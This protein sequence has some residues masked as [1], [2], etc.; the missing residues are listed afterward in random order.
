[1]Q[2][3]SLIRRER[4]ARRARSAMVEVQPAQ[5]FAGHATRPDA[6]AGDAGQEQGLQA[7]R[8]AA[9]ADALQGRGHVPGMHAL[10]GER[11]RWW[12]G[13]TAWPTLRCSATPRAR[14]S[15]FGGFGNMNA[16]PAR[17]VLQS[18]S[19]VT[20]KE[21]D[22]SKTDDAT[23]GDSDL[24]S[25]A[26]V[27]RSGRRSDGRARKIAAACHAGP[28]KDRCAEG[29]GGLSAKPGEQNGV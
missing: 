16:Y 1:M 17:L 5:N 2:S 8:F 28:C 23:K 12:A 24:H 26:A 22:Y 3:G 11:R 4:R 6:H 20:P 13:W 29:R 10:Q 9:G 27:T 21:I 7:V 19:D 15:G 18:V 25:R 14:L